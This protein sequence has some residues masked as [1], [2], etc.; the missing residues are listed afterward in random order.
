VGSLVGAILIA[1]IAAQRGSAFEESE[2][3]ALVPYPKELRLED[4]RLPLS[5]AARIVVVD[6]VLRPHADVLAA[7]LALVAGLR[8]EVIGGPA[9]AGDIVLKLSAADEVNP[10]ESHVLEVADR[11]VVVGTTPAAVA[12]GTA[13]LL[14]TLHVA[15]A[16]AALPR[17]RVADGPA[18]PYCGAML[19]LARKPYS[20]DTLQQCIEVCRFYKIRF[21][22]L[23][24]T[25][26]NAWT[27]PSTAFPELGS[28]NF[29]WAGGEAPRVYTREELTALVAYAEA[30]GVT[31]VPE[32]ELP[33][34]SGQ[35]RGTLPEVFG[36]TNAAGETVSLGVINLV[37]E[38]SLAAV[39]QIIAEV[40]EV[41]APSP[42][43]HLGCDEVWLGGVEDMPEVQRYATDHR[44]PYPHA[45]FNRF[46]HHL[47][48]CV[49][50]HGKR[51]IVW[52]GAPLDPD[53]LPRDTI[54][55]PWVGHSAAATDL[56]RLGYDV[57]NA[58][59]GVE[60]PYMDVYRVNQAQLDAG[61]PHLLG[62]TS[63]LWESPA[64]RAVPY[65]RFTGA[66]R[67]EPTYHPDSGRGLDDFLPRL[68]RIDARLDRLLCGVALDVA[69][70]IDPRRHGTLDPMFS[71]T[72]TVGLAEGLDP[73]GVRYTLD[74]SEPTLDS[75][76]WGSPLKLERTTTLR[77]R[78]FDDA[79]EPVA[80]MLEKRFVRLAPLPHAAIDAT[81]SIDPERPGYYGPGPA[82]LV[83]GV[84]AATND[85]SA[86][87]WV[88]WE[89][90]GTPVTI[91][92]D[93]GREQELRQVVVHCLRS[94]GGVGL[95]Q[96]VELTVSDDGIDYR[97]A[98]RTSGEEAAGERGW[99][100]VEPA[101]TSARYLRLTLTHGADW[102]F[103]DEIA[104]NPT[105]PPPAVNHAARGKAVELAHAPT[106]YTAPGT[107]GLT[108]GYT[109]DAA[110]FLSLEWLGFEFQP[111]VATIDLGAVQPVHRV[112]ARFLQEV[113]GGIY[114]PHALE[115]E[116]SDDG[117]AFR[118]A[119]SLNRQSNQEAQYIATL[120][121]DL[122]ETT[123]R[124]VRVTA[125]P[126]GQWLFVDEVLVDPQAA[127]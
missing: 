92:L 28:Q 100:V 78:R 111:L 9:R 106:S 35:L 29:A 124:Y 56:V 30:R 42:Y 39:D 75:A 13:T 81:I 62:A 112:A 114:V 66:L 41:F 103:V 34:H 19:D 22:Q 12:Q 40:A 33:G 76:A 120:S 23:H 93:L 68:Q 37:S 48:G 52:E 85:F 71:G 105:L 20:I 98:G 108:D 104:V 5:T 89:N 102:T 43:I 2:V 82:G 18:L 57:I 63:I 127:E 119:G 27:F 118:P 26:E 24:M 15:G 69:G 123:A 8:L 61:E 50:R 45:V 79:G 70:T 94:A 16:E 47:H 113:R 3:A 80:A 32:I 97:D 95:P 10:H 46:V 107:A 122:G 121:V 115:V 117:R 1:V 44:L 60:R 96:Q 99:F 72:A 67:N 64:D 73:A 49:A 58:P 55:M 86:P 7:E 110:N 51:L 65:L 17:M 88:G 25:D 21:L 4:G 125:R 126:S 36:Y 14:Q 116:V 74:G 84:L 11:A 31:L 77:V 109:S 38:R 53:P 91:N 90:R 6:D 59:W 83:D 101:S 87:G 54:F